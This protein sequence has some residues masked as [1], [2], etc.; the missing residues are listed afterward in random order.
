MLLPNRILHSLRFRQH[1]ADIAHRAAAL[2]DQSFLKLAGGVS[3]PSGDQ[4][5]VTVP[6]VG[7]A[8]FQGIRA[9][10]SLRCH[11]HRLPKANS[12]IRENDQERKFIL[13]GAA[14]HVAATCGSHH[15]N[16]TTLRGR[17]DQGG[18][19]ARTV[20]AAAM[21]V[22]SGSRRRRIRGGGVALRQ[23][24]NIVG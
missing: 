19:Q 14:V 16:A 21:V 18:L 17:H 7:N 1:P 2:E 20:G 23:R 22:A 11:R 10:H 12:S 9:N 6:S 5:S 24:C 15:G 4:K 3:L 8:G 13:F